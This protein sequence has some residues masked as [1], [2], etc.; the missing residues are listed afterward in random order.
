MQP[1]IILVPA[2]CSQ[3]TINLPGGV[4]Y[5]AVPTQPGGGA[6]LRAVTVKD[7]I[8]DLPN[9]GNGFS[10]WVLLGHHSSLSGDSQPQE[11]AFVSC[12][13]VLGVSAHFHSFSTLFWLARARIL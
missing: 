3:L 13:H 7:A 4:A 12:R 11:G 9:I 10:Q 5:T 8:A 2:H 1:L 6:A